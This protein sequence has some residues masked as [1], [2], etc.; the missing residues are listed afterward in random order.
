MKIKKTVTDKVIAANQENGKKSEGPKDASHVDQNARTHGW[1]SKHL[2]LQSEEERQEFYLLLDELVDEY[3]PVLRTDIEL[4]NELAVDIWTLGDQNGWGMQALAQGRKATAAILKSLAE[5]YDGE[6]LPLFTQQDG[7]HSAVQ[8]GW[9]CQELVVR[10][11]TRNS[12][13]EDEG[14]SGDRRDKSGHVQI[15]A[16]LDTSLDTMLRYQAARKRDMYRVIAELRSRQRERRGE[17][18]AGEDKRQIHRDGQP[19]TRRELN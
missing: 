14:K 16:R 11:G 4:V 2:M 3:Q 6:Q 8:F 10:T 18:V 5:N 12:E 7:S 13:Q 17:S 19:K 15:E 9:D 1:L